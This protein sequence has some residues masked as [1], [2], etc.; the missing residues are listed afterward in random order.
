ML[1][2]RR[3]T[4]ERG[5]VGGGTKR[6]DA[7]NQIGRIDAFRSPA[8]VRGRDNPGAEVRLHLP[9]KND[10]AVAHRAMNAAKLAA[11]RGDEAAARENA[12]RHVVEPAEAVTLQSFERGRLLAGPAEHPG[13]ETGDGGIKRGELQLLAVAEKQREVTFGYAGGLR[14]LPD[15]DAVQTDS[16]CGAQCRIEDAGAR[17]VATRP[18]SVDFRG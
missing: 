16:R 1:E 8:F 2:R 11:H 17:P 9:A 18:T 12:V 3:V 7:M 15:G 13:P 14:E 10:Q 4:Q 5:D 6:Q